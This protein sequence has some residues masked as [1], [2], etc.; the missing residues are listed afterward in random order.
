MLVYANS[1]LDLA[2]V[3]ETKHV[4]LDVFRLGIRCVYFIMNHQ[5]VGTKCSWRRPFNRKASSILIN[6]DTGLHMRYIRV[7]AVLKHLPVY[8]PYQ[9][10]HHDSCSHKTSLEL[11]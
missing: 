3:Q 6:T 2:T 11:A 8:R 7:L 1:H 5:L 9:Q 10:A 4:L